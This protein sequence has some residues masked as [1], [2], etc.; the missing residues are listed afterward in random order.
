MDKAGLSASS[1][2]DHHNRYRGGGYSH[3][4]DNLPH[5][6]SVSLTILLTPTATVRKIPLFSPFVITVDGRNK[7]YKGDID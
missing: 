4:T 3:E 2:G 6:I 5:L 1:D 7:S